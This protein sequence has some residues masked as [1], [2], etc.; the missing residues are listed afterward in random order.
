MKI[1]KDIVEVYKYES[2]KCR[3][4]KACITDVNNVWESKVVEQIL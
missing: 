2:S 4:F 3:V 1:G